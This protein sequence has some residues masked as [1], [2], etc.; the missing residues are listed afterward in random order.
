[1]G[2]ERDVSAAADA[3]AHGL[4]SSA[5]SS[6][7][8]ASVSSSNAG[9]S[10]SASISA[11]SAVENE[12]PA[13]SRIA[14]RYI[15]QETIGRGGTAIVYRV[16]D[17][18]SG[19]ALALK[20]LSVI[21]DGRKGFGAL[22]E[23]EFHTLAQLSH[24]SVIEVYDYGLDGG[25]PYYTM[26]LLDGGDLR[27]RSP[28]P[29]KQAC[30][31]LHDVCSSLA[32]LHSRRLLHRDVGPRNIRCTQDGR[33]KLID[34]G[35]MVPMGPC[36]QVVGTPP[37]VPPE[38]VYRASL[39]GRTDL[40]SLGATLYYAL[41]KRMA[42]PARELSQ[43]ARVWLNKPP[44]PST[45]AR[46]VPP[47]LDALVMSLISLEPAVRPASAFE[48]M[49]KLAAI[50]GIDRRERAEVQ[51]AYLTTP[52]LVGRATELAT[53]RTQLRCALGGRGGTMMINGPPGSGRSRMLD[54]CALE[55]KTIGLTVLRG[56]ASEQPFALVRQLATQALEELP[57][58][59]VRCLRDEALVNALLEPPRRATSRPKLRDLAALEATTDAQAVQAALTTMLL[60][61]SQ[62]QAIA[63]LIDDV[64]LSDAESVAVLASLASL[65]EQKR[66]MLVLTVD[67]SAPLRATSA[68]EVLRSYASSITLEPLVAAE[69]HALLAS[70][71]GDV[72][73]LAVVTTH[74]HAASA[75]L[76][77][78]CIEMAEHLVKRGLA[79]YSGGTWSLPEE[80]DAATLPVSTIDVMRRKI[81]ELSPLARELARSQALSVQ[82]ALGREHYTRL[83]P[84]EA[85]SAIDAAL[86]ELVASGVLAG[87]GALYR[88]AN[89][90]STSLLDEGLSDAQRVERHA[91]LARVY[92]DLGGSPIL[93]VHHLLRGG[94]EA[95]G[96]ERFLSYLEKITEGRELS[97]LRDPLLSVADVALLHS[98]ALDVAEQLGKSP[99]TIADL[100]QWLVLVSVATENAH[101]WKAAPA[102][103]ARLEHDSGLDL[104]RALTDETD[105][106]ARL[107][108]AFT[109]ALARYEATPA[110][111]RCY[112]PDEA[113]RKLVQYVVCSMPIATRTIDRPLLKSLP[114]LLEPFVALSPMV[115][116]VWENALASNEGTIYGKY[117]EARARWLNTYEQLGT[118]SG[119]EARYVG[120]MRNAVAYGVATLE[121]SMG[122]ATAERWAEVLDD[123]PL[124]RVN[125]MY[126]RRV[127]A[128]QRGDADEAERHRKQAEL[129]AAQ[130]TVRQMFTSL[131]SV[132]LAAFARARDLTGVQ[133]L[134]ARIELLAAQA[135]PWL[136][137]KHL[138]DGYFHQICGEH[139]AALAAFERCLA[140]ATPDD[141]DD[142][143]TT[144]CWPP[145]S[146]AYIEALVSLGRADE[147]RTFGEHTLARGRQL[148][149]GFGSLEI[150]RMLALAE[151]HLG[152]HESAARRLE[153][154]AHRQ[155]AVGV[156][157]LHLGATYEA[158][159]RVAILAGDH[160]A[161]EEYGRRTAREY[162]HGHGSPLGARYER[163]MDDARLAGLP[164][165]PALSELG[166]ALGGRSWDRSQ[167]T[168]ALIERKLG[169]ARNAKERA[170]RALQLLCGARGL[171]R[172]HLYLHDGTRLAHAAAHGA[173][174]PS[175]ELTESLRAF[176]ERELQAHEQ[177][178]AVLDDVHSAR[179]TQ[180]T[181]RKDEP[182]FEPVCLSYMDGD[183]IVHVGVLAI[184][185]RK[186]VATVMSTTPLIEAMAE[187]LASIGD[188]PGV[189]IAIQLPATAS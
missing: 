126:L 22:F 137:Y 169:P 91:Q 161:V 4:L 52:T 84:A 30:E 45:Y 26:E 67:P 35:A 43:L 39:D 166:G 81:A 119:P 150:E 177:I 118:V 87:D 78:T 143:R 148:G 109:Q 155:L 103:R 173:P 105:P 88:L 131:L 144:M 83:A 2:D 110:E 10:A 114:G 102:W 33:A 14:D 171:G 72:A 19:R 123:D 104:Y 115:R 55:A 12:L 8:R 90:A 18:S 145:G 122:I 165:L 121:A 188:A 65:A 128:L 28:V 187:H 59:S 133:Q 5:T 57:E 112:R 189:R 113:I 135:P 46:D 116:A 64:H 75:G 100:R 73:N 74:L 6:T 120:L 68:L 63:L 11:G 111:A 7:S 183:T 159:T 61:V 82:R 181:S 168:T 3:A 13:L 79:R 141:D 80:L 140:M 147:A 93:V 70:V 180:A 97:T 34:F 127:M 182:A 50:A 49:Q 37:F 86:T 184:E 136:A 53:L 29:W 178:T 38:A 95:I 60:R 185:L 129:L 1:L 9:A 156:Q 117:L 106:A 77:R 153:D 15:V 107:S 21:D 94:L 27:E 186:G 101:Y 48:V 142:T 96:I 16:I 66:I 175:A 132:E 152:E 139:E 54:A 62:S 17:E 42:Y 163:L 24:P 108:K 98:R 146:A 179:T 99:R 89:A 162:R 158:R 124:Q 25:V 151:A 172:G 92:A 20:R 134:R 44:L 130:S 174:E 40:Y 176:F 76:P 41:T 157:G 138:A 160:A 164:L 69:T 71:F 56:C 85:N 51:A 47:A 149:L 167:S 31:L 36:G 170:E 32:L 125:A 58:A 154:I 23:R